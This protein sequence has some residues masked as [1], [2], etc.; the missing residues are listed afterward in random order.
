ME[1]LRKNFKRGTKVTIDGSTEYLLS[2]QYA[3]DDHWDDGGEKWSL[4]FFF[5]GRK[6]IKEHDLGHAG[7]PFR[8]GYSKYLLSA[9]SFDSF[10]DR[11]DFFRYTMRDGIKVKSVECYSGT[12]P[13]G[14]G[15]AIASV[16]FDDGSVCKADSENSVFAFEDENLQ[17]EFRS[18]IDFVGEYFGSFLRHNTVP[19][20]YSLEHLLLKDNA[21]ITEVINRAA[22]NENIDL[23]NPKL[24]MF[25]LCW[26]HPVVTYSYSV[27]LVRRNG[28]LG[29]EIY[30]SEND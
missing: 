9:L 11:R 14:E 12:S 10:L 13:S 4:A 30:A 22:K 2:I 20:W 7:L 15:W 16:T 26:Q 25:L 17:Y 24:R 23:N 5:Q 8:E 3:R 21:F 18:C 29:I 1:W 28:V 27:T 6:V 19:D